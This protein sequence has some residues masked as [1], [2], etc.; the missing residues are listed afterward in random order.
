MPHLVRDVR[1][2]IRMMARTPVMAAVVIVSLGIGIGVNTVVFAWMQARLLRPLPGVRAAA[3]LQLVEPKTGTG[4]YPGMSW[5]EYRD[6]RARLRSFS[7][8][9]AFRMVPLYVGPSGDVERMYGLF[10]SDN[11]FS[12]LGLRPALGRFPDA[13]GRES[14]AVISHGLWQA[15]YGSAANAIG[16]PIRINGQGF[17]VAAVAPREFQGTVLGLNFAVWIPAGLA[18]VLVNGTRELEDR[19]MRGYSAMGRLHPSAS[20]AQAQAELEASMRHL[21]V[22]YP[23][24]NTGVGG[25]VLPFWQTPRGP[26][27]L[28]VTALVILQ[29]L[30][31]LLL[32]AVCGN[33]ANLVLAR[34]SARQR[35]MGVRLALGAGPWRVA[36]LLLT[37]TVVLGLL[38]GVLGAG[39]AVWGTDALVT[40]PLTG[41]PIR[42]QTSVDGLVVAFAIALGVLSG[43]LV[44]LPPALHLA[45][46]DPQLAIRAGARTAA[47]SPLRNAL[48]AVQVALALVVLIMAGLFFKS[49]M[50]TRDVNPGFRRDGVLLAAYDLSGRNASAA[51]VKAF[52]RR[53]LDDLRALPSIAG[54]AIASS[55]PLDIHGLP[56]RTFALQARA[57]TDGTLDRTLANTVTPGY[58]AVMDIPLQAGKD[59]VPLDDESTAPQ[60]IVNEA[61]VRMYLDGIEPIGRRLESRGRT[62]EIAGVV[63]NSL[64]NAFGEPPTPIVY[65]SYRDD[66]LPL[67][68]LH[69]RARTGAEAPLTPEVRRVIREIDPELPLF[70]VR[71]LN[72]HVETN[73]VFRRVPARLFG[74]LGPML[75]M[76]AGIGIYAVVAYTVSLRTSEIGVRL[77]LG[78]TAHRIVGQLVGEGLAITTLGALVGWALALMIAMAVIGDRAL[79]PVVFAGVPA[80]LLG[81]A[82]FACWLPAHRASRVEPVTALRHE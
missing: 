29:G 9:F 66:T 74:V 45:R 5:S 78:A 41:L 75:L 63:R 20:R 47:S 3:D 57:R 35:E 16:Q 79:D 68:E 2:A 49:F 33:T 30:M 40:L 15:R 42:F 62:Y 22:A 26:Q 1:Q 61:F 7:D 8:L 19:R 13:D 31:L 6:L 69:L 58:F 77:A 55:V 38:G 37:E 52:P 65:F 11:Y 14:V 10:V 27:R 53:L 50:E 21:A 36:S 43:V 17:T 39:V 28:L 48:M 51:F 82:A 56:E 23:Q 80:I 46:T 81:V 73:L 54:A 59:F 34:A 18:P 44:G 4:A 76:L 25:E 72:D 64:Y 12:A 71:T 24:S 60:A 32:L 70:N 67:G